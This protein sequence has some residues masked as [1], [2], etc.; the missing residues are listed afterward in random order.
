[1]PSA[2]KRPGGGDN[3]P[4]PE[5]TPARGLY[6]NPPADQAEPARVDN[7]V[8]SEL[9]GKPLERWD[10]IDRQGRSAIDRFSLDDL[11]R[12]CEGDPAAADVLREAF[13][14]FIAHRR[15]GSTCAEQCKLARAVR[16][17]VVLDRPLRQAKA[18]LRASR[19]G[20]ADHA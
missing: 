20:G 4:G 19:K 6:H 3:A 9:L 1:M 16:K 11:L 18:A 7:D 5:K 17:Q 10:L 15:P 12:W 2:N 13:D 8:A 14:L